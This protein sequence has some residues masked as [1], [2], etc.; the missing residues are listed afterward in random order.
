MSYSFNKNG[1]NLFI[2][3]N[4]SLKEIDK[5]TKEQELKKY[6]LTDDKIYRIYHG[7]V[8]QPPFFENIC[9]ISQKPSILTTENIKLLWNMLVPVYPVIEKNEQTPR[10]PLNK[11]FLIVSSHFKPFFEKQFKNINPTSTLNN[12]PSIILLNEK[13]MVVQKREGGLP[14]YQNQIKN[15]KSIELYKR[16]FYLFPSNRIVDFMVAGTMKGGT[17]AIVHNFEKHPEISMTPYELHFF[18]NPEKYQLGMDYY[19]SFFDYT[20]KC[21]GDKAPDIMYQSEAMALLQRVN[22]QVKIILILRDPIERCF[23]HWK[24]TKTDYKNRKS[25]EFCVQDEIKNRMGENRESKI[26]FYSH[27]IQRGFYYTQ[28]QELLKYFPR[29][30][31]LII[32][33][34]KVRKDMYFYYNQIFEFIGVQQV[35][36]ASA[37]SD[38]ASSASSDSSLLP[39]E[40]KEYHIGKD[41]TKLDKKSKIY[42]QLKEIFT[43][44]VQ[45]LEEYL[46]IKT[47]WME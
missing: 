31:M 12:H 6:L 25:F 5:I 20:K 3:D 2:F 29:H 8:Y 7:L 11:G 18:D 19:K 45:Q 33:S 36:S 40:F 43:K 27:F 16:I 32:I 1:R 9:C 44:E 46:G 26:A 10:F 35:A 38:S 17:E 39:L 4:E 13:R 22:P 34:E 47:N 23:S 24:M 30:N 28:I 15:E 14:P 37:S 41:L 21:V 42:K